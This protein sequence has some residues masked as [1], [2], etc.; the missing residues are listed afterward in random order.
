MGFFEKIKQGLTRTRENIGHS[1]DQLF[2]GELDDDFYDIL[3]ETLILSDMGVDTALEVSGELRKRTKA[4][5]IKTA[6]EA[7]ECLKSIL[8]EILTVGNG[9][10]NMEN[11][12]AVCLFI[13]V[14]GVGKTTTIGKLAARMK[15]EGHK[16]LPLPPPLTSWRSGHSGRGWTLCGR[17]REPTP[18]PWSLTPAPPPRPGRV[19]WCWWTQPGG[20]TISRI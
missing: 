9:E 17:G 5:K 14:N 16:V 6:A 12:P 11:R 10:L 18:P 4:E 19:I 15:G 1:F 20:F 13:G 7:R 3:E 8:V 2:A